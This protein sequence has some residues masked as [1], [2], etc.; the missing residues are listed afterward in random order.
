MPFVKVSVG[1]PLSE[2]ECLSVY[3]IVK[4]NISVIPGKTVDNSMV[5]VEG[6]ALTFMKAEKM[7]CVFI[8]VR[9]YGTAPQEAKAEFVEKTCAGI[10]ELLGI[11]VGNIYMNIQEF[12]NFGAGGAWK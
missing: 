11:G 1:K 3:D 10:S 5:Q 2:V 4:D 9:L 7:P 8:D 6:N 12:S